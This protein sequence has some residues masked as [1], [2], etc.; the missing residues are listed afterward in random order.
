MPNDER[1]LTVYDATQLNK[2]SSYLCEAIITIQEQQPELL[3]EK[4]RN[5]EWLSS[6]NKSAL[7]RKFTEI[8]S[9][10]QD[11]D[12]LPQRLQGYLKALLIP[13]SINSPILKELIEKVNQLNYIK[14]NLNGFVSTTNIKSSETVALTTN[15][16]S[17]EN[18]GITVLLLDAENLHINGDTEKFLTTVCNFPIQ[19][20][21]AFANW[22][23]MGRL[24]VELHGRGYD[25]IHVPVGRDN[26]DGKMIAFGSSIHDR[27]PNAKEVLV[28]SSDKV[29]TN[30]CNHLQQNGLI[31]YRVSKKD[32]GISIFNSYTGNIT[33]F[34]TSAPEIPTVEQFIQQVKELIKAEQKRHQTCWIKLATISQAFKNKYNLTIA[35]VVSQHLPGKKAR[36]IFINFPADLVVHQVDAASE[37]Y[38]TIFE[39]NE[40]QPATSK[41]DTPPSNI[42]SPLLSSINSKADLE[43][44]IKNI[45]NEL[46]QQSPGSYINIGNLGGTFKNQYG[47]PISEQMKSL[48][49]NGTFL[50]FLQS[51]SSLKLKKTE[52]GWEVTTS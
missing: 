23:S 37:L 24:D 15:S 42:T 22:C 3:L 13:E 11:W 51:C 41:D 34:P 26:A 47:K 43:L 7:T 18:K 2:I 49:L 50:K 35:Q 52:K 45:I 46:T 36:D 38:L 5:V 25:L 27:Y 10:A 33:H 14:T 17:T 16:F 19:V 40:S 39:I 12:A 1:L 44:V 30:L 8:F 32:E 28:C 48:Q 20:K 29:M 21:I 31:V 9:Q 6:A 4:Y